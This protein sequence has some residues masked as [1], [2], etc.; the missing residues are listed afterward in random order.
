MKRTLP[1]DPTWAE[2]ESF[3][4]E[5]AHG[6]AWHW[7]DEHAERFS[8]HGAVFWLASA[9]HSGQRSNL[10]AALGECLYRPGPLESAASWA[11]SDPLGGMLLDA[12]R[13]ALAEAYGRTR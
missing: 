12:F 7:E 3:A 9:C 13:D 4:H 8:F 1:S 11:D 5:L 6:C 2:L 10:Y